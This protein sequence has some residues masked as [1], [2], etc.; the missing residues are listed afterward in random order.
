GGVGE[1]VGPGGAGATA[2][3]RVTP[4][5]SKTEV[6]ASGLTPITI[7]SSAGSVTVFSR[8][9]ADR[10]SAASRALAALSASPLTDGTVTFLALPVLT[11]MCTT[12]PGRV[13][14]PV[15]SCVTTV[16]A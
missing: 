10:L 11:S 3:T 13:V 12:A 1:G 4:E 14:P 6:P 9:P 16:P 8:T 15:G 7:P 5:H 2:T